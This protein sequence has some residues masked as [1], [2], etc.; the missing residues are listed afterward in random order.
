MGHAAV[1]DFPCWFPTSRGG[2]GASVCGWI[3]GIIGS[4]TMSH[5][6]GSMSQAAS[7]LA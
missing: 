6:A 5:A 3:I 1:K 2:F 4:M 7:K